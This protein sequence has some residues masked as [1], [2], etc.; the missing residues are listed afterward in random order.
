MG[1]RSRKRARTPAER[2]AAPRK[3]PAAPKRRAS[4]SRSE[5]KDAEARAA[6]EPLGEGER[7]T[8][9]TVAAV[10]AFLLAIVNLAAGVAGLEIRGREQ[11]IV[12]VAAYS[13]VMLVAAW[14]MWGSRYWAVL[15]MEA[16][17]GILILIF[18]GLL[19]IASNALAVVVCVTV[20]ASAGTL[21]WFLIKAMARIQM[22][23]RRT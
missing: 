23:E 3:R 10:V 5:L 6:L 21:F 7:P 9:V 12:G 22:P 14:G 13:A 1:R 17:L 19:I 8:A 15:G 2:P 20:I 16:L 18:S 4:P 11:P